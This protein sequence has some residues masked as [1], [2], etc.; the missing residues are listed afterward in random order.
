MVLCLI[1]SCKENGKQDTN[2]AYTNDLIHETS[3]YLLQHAH[4]PV[5]WQ[6]WNDDVLEEAK[7]TNKLILISIGYSSCHW[8]HVMERETFE[9]KE[10]AKLMNENFINIKV[11]REERPDIDQ[12]YQTAAQLQGQN[13]GWPLN[14]ISLPNGKPLYLGTYHTKEQWME[15]LTNVN[16]QFSDDP[17]KA[18]E[19]ADRLAAGIEETNVFTPSSEFEKLTK[20]TLQSGVDS[21]KENWDS[22]LGGDK[23]QQKFPVPNSLDFLLDYAVVTN[24]Q[25]VLTHVKNTLDQMT[26]GGIY[27]HLGG[28]FFRYST[29]PQWKVP[30]FEKMLYDNAQLIGLY[31]KAFKVFN[32]PIYKDVVF[33]TIAFLNREMKNP[34][35]GYYAALDADSEGEEGKFYIWKK[36]ELQAVLG[37]DF[38]LFS[39][40]YNIEP[41]NV[42]ENDSYILYKNGSDEAFVKGHQISKEE[43]I[44]KKNLWKVA[45]MKARD[46]RIR[47]NTD[48]KVLSSW[49]SLLISGLVEAYAAFGEKEFLNQAISIYDFIQEKSYNNGQLKHSHK[50][51]SKGTE[52]FLEDYAFLS[53]AAIQLYKVS[54]NTSYL[55]FANSLTKKTQEGFLDPTSGLYRFNDNENL[56]SNIIK[57]HDGDIPSPNSVMA[58]NLFQLGHINYNVDFSKQSKTMLTTLLPYVTDYSSS[59]ANWSHL[60]LKVSHPFYEIAVVGEDAQSKV[61]ALQNKHIPN[62]III[63]SQDDSELPL[64]EDR[65]QAGE[66]YIYVCQDRVCKLPVNT[67]GDAI[68]QLENF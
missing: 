49:N 55:N 59:Y 62:T 25:E 24:D 5:N 41:S 48:D 32:E 9:D 68:K 18:A 34:Q 58:N 67:V 29:D 66:T 60:L 45:L 37:D 1:S 42:W 7:K 50:E 17:Q 39:A 6:A 35:G 13:G 15:V 22:V 4:N 3:P 10:V 27:D 11:D 28:G 40:Y 14:A 19:Y 47:P 51:G 54:L 53:Q 26:N 33:E 56:I 8:C 46:A 61:E 65:F 57:T 38:T 63:G 44:Q 30:H 16:K 12:V 21:W 64:F 52:G 36:A 23:S 2:H 20:E 31:S 43:L